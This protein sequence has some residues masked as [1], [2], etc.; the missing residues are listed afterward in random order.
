VLE[1]A[2]TRA[3]A[4]PIQSAFIAVTETARSGHN[5]VAS[6]STG[7]SFNKPFVNILN[8]FICYVPAPQC[9]TL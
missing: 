4:I 2:K 8:L 6:T 5:P 1:K 7:F 9:F 3:V